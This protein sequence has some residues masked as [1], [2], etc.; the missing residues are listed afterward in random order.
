MA[1]LIITS[2]SNPRLKS[3]AGLRRRRTREETGQTLIE[4]YEEL[5]LALGAGVRPEALYYWVFPNV[6]LNLYPDNLQVIVILPLTAERTVTRVEWFVL[7]PESPGVAEEFAKSFAFS[8]QVQKE[9]IGICEAV[10]KNLR[11]RTYDQGR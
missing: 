9:D 4:G 10:Q 7:D 3:L 1:D 2:P 11:S 5:T 6:M 8:D